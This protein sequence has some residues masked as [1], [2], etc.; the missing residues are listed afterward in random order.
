MLKKNAK[1]SRQPK[2]KLVQPAEPGA[3][4]SRSRSSSRSSTVSASASSST[5]SST[6]TLL[7]THTPT[8]RAQKI[9]LAKEKLAQCEENLRL[10]EYKVEEGEPGTG[11]KYSV[12]HDFYLVVDARSGLLERAAQCKKC[13][14]CLAYDV[15]GAGSSHLK[16]HGQVTCTKFKGDELGFEF[17]PSPHE[18]ESL[19]V[20]K[21]ADVAEATLFSLHYLPHA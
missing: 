6:L 15:K 18:A 4:R 14:R 17:V 3:R 21:M 13:R 1:K 16:N 7:P 10:G 5:T 12:W 8:L 20:D 19:F 11:G 2:P 9:A